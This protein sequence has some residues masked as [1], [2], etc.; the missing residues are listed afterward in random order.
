MNKMFLRRFVSMA[1]VTSSMV[2]GVG[3]AGIA[4][5]ASNTA[6]TPQAASP[7]TITMQQLAKHVATLPELASLKDGDQ[8]VISDDGSVTGAS[9]QGTYIYHPAGS[10]VPATAMYAR[11]KDDLVALTPT[12]A[13]EDK[14]APGT[15][16]ASWV[17]DNVFSDTVISRHQTIATLIT[18]PTD[19]S[20][21]RIPNYAWLFR[22]N[23]NGQYTALV[24]TFVFV[25]G[26]QPLY[27]EDA[28][29]QVIGPICDGSGCRPAGT[30]ASTLVALGSQPV[31]VSSGY[32]QPQ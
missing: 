10:V 5:A 32:W 16:D 13:T 15:L 20:V 3:F 28:A 7:V 9:W 23:S 24:D 19:S 29:G 21:L 26:S 8:V 4:N 30:T 31:A 25:S 1:A 18:D 12:P 14:P 11:W 17:A 22:V 6:E 2:L 27:P